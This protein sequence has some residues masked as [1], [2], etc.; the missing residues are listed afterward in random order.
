M[1][2]DK[3][4]LFYNPNEGKI[5]STDLTLFSTNT[6]KKSLGQFK[7]FLYNENNQVVGELNVINNSVI[8]KD[9]PNIV[10]DFSNYCFTI[11]IDTF[12]EKYSTTFVNGN[13]QR[14]SQEIFTDN[15]VRFLNLQCDVGTPRFTKLKWIISADNEGNPLPRTLIFYN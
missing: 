13:E 14:N 7:F 9:T 6:L 4:V 5:S 10:D 11:N 2:C 8:Y 3:L 12:V 1:N 15:T